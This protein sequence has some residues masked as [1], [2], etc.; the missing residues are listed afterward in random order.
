MH[1]FLSRNSCKAVEK[2]DDEATPR[3]GDA[4]SGDATNGEAAGQEATDGETV[5]REQ[6]KGV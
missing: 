2:A 3:G 6:T 4:Q 1:L 5:Q